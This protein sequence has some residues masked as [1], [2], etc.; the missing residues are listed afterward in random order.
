[1]ITPGQPFH[2]LWLSKEYAQSNKGS[3]KRI[4]SIFSHF[5]NGKKK[6]DDIIIIISKM[7]LCSPHF[8]QS[9]K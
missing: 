5:A 3:P 8:T 1:M 9:N 2:S 6:Y 7:D 4:I